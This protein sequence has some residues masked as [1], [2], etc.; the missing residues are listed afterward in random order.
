MIF[1]CEVVDPV[2]VQAVA[3]TVKRALA[4]YG[5]L[6]F[7]EIIKNCMSQDFSWKV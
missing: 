4:T 2:D 3:T 6:A 7:A 5:T 1:Q